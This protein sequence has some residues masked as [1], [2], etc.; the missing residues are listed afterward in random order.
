MHKLK[1]RTSKG[2]RFI[3]HLTR[4][5]SLLDIAGYLRTDL[6]RF[7]LTSLRLF[8]RPSDR[9]VSSTHHI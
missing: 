7:E 9:L 3:S 1:S 8:C 4:C 2:Q 6:W 5:H